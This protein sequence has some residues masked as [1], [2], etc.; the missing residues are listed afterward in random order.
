MNKTLKTKAFTLIEVLVVTAVISLLASVVNAQLGDARDKADD[1]H[2]K[3]EVGQVRNAVEQYRQKN[4]NVPYVASGYTAGSMVTEGEPEYD[5][6][7]EQLVPDY[8]SS[9]P[10]SPNGQSYSYLAT[11]DGQDAVFVAALNNPSSGS[12]SNSCEVIG[13]SVYS[14]CEYATDS[15]LV[16]Y[17]LCDG[18]TYDTENKICIEYSDVTGICVKPDVVCPPFGDYSVEYEIVGDDR[19]TNEIC[20]S[21]LY[22]ACLGAIPIG[23]P[24]PVICDI[25][26]GT[27]SVC[28]GSSNSDYCSCI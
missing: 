14:N 18:Y 2:M 1:A 16:E 21:L 8:M 6:L 5:A 19:I 11:T 12:N 7:M 22:N 23:P 25:P 20:S 10:T 24:E 9:V 27:T 15:S 3:Q 17:W 26:T 4:G 13:S 28:S